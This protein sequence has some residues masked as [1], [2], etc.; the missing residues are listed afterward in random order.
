M[1]GFRVESKMEEKVMALTV[2]PGLK[3]DIIDYAVQRGYKGI[4][5]ECYGAGG[6]NTGRDN[7]LPAIRRAIKAG[8]RMVC[9]SQCLFD[10]VDLS[11]YPMGILAAQAGVESGGPMT[12]E[13]AV[14][15]LMWSLA[16][17]A[18]EKN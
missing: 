5:L 3:P 8:V 1:G 7:L 18:L 2:T 10:G 9:V 4:V 12:L 15:K 13:A 16:N 6:V 14:T 11:L 17:P